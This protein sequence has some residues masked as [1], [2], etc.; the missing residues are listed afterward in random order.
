M[1]PS[2]SARKAISV[3][4]SPGRRSTRKPRASSSWANI[5]ASRYD[6]PNGLEA[7]TTGRGRAGAW[8]ASRSAS[9][10][11]GHG[12][13]PAPGRS[14]SLRTYAR[15]RALACSSS[16]GATCSTRPACIT[17]TRSARRKASARSCVT[18]SAVSV[19]RRAAPRGRR[20]QIGAG[21][22]VE[23]AERLVEQ[24]DVGLRGERAR[25][26]DA[27]A[28]AARQL[29]RP[30]IA[31]VAPARAR[32]AGAPARPRRPARASPRSQG[33]SATLRRTRQCGQ[34][35]AVLRHVPDPAAQGDR[36]ER[37]GVL[38]RPPAPGPRRDR[39]A[40]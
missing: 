39:P 27:L 34:Q 32:P 8:S 30:A 24:H 10:M 11:T 16:G 28:L 26:G 5:S 12:S 18:S 40:D 13:D 31:E 2:R 17:A 29:A 36:I 4:P 25:H 1:A 23:R 33:T 22:R 35:S 7:T 37:R 19:E 14:S 21:D 3:A 6:S 9:P 15:G 20:L 38:R